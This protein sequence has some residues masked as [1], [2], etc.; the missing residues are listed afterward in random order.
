MKKKEADIKSYSISEAKEE[1]KNGIAAYLK[2]DTKGNYQYPLIGRLP[3]YLEGAPGLGKTEIVKQIAEEL[4][5]GFVSFSVTHHTRNSLIGLPVIKDLKHGKYTEYTMSEIIARVAAEEEA[6]KE[7]GILLLDEFNCASETIMPTML[8]FLQT[9]NIG[10]YRLPDNWVIVLCGNPREYNKSAKD[11]SPAIL[12]RVR[13]LNIENDQ[14]VLLEYG[15]EKEFHPLVL[16]FLNWNRDCGYRVREIE[17]ETEVVTNRGWENLS[18]ALKGY[19]ACG[20]P[21]SEKMIY[22]FIKSQDIADKFYRHYWMN[23]NAFGTEDVEKVFAGKELDKIADRLNSNDVSFK[24]NA[25]ELLKSALSVKTAGGAKNAAKL[26]GMIENVFELISRLSESEVIEENFFFW[27][28]ET[29]NMVTSLSRAPGEHYLELCKKAY[30]IT[31][32]KGA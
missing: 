6:G 2:K 22:Q 26:T 19:E 23:N 32:K 10:M 30:G 25:L 18:R 3:F 9:R 11:F 21:V 1:I 4:G 28:N 5:I 24:W 12:D 17:G 7:E 14:S 31:S 16:S 20:I 8:A 27:L 15:E 29:E 13:R